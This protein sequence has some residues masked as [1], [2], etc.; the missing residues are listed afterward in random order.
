M[1]F[2][3]DTLRQEFAQRADDKRRREF[4]RSEKRTRR[5]DSAKLEDAA[6]EELMAISFL[7]S[8]DFPCFSEIL[9]NGIFVSCEVIHE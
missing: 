3:T 8:A 2:D 1:R 4:E 6:D 7:N 5:E 9:T